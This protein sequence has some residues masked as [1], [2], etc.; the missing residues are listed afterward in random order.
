M[1]QLV[2]AS[3]F[4]Q[5]LTLVAAIDAGALPEADERI[6]VLAD[7]SQTPELTVPLVEQDG[8]AVVAS[9]FDRVVDLAALLDPLRP[10]QF[11]PR[12][13]EHPV[14]ER[15]LRSHWQLGDGP[16]QVVMDFV[17]VDPAFSLAGIFAEA[18]LW[19][20]SDGLMTYSPTRRSLPLRI[21][22]RLC[23]LVHLDLVPGLRPKML[24]EYDVPQ[25]RVPLQ[26]LWAVL[27]EVLQASAGAADPS[28][29][30]RPTALVLGQYLSSLGVVSAEEETALNARL[31]VEAA[32]SGA[33]VCLF[34]PHPAAPPA[35]TLALQAAAEGAGIDLVID[36]SPEI[37]ELTMRRRKPHWVISCFSTGLA[38]ARYLL[39]IEAVA[40]GTRELLVRLNPYENSNRVPL[41]LAHLLFADRPVGGG[42]EAPQETETTDPRRDLQRLVDAVAYCMQPVLL[43]GSVEDVRDYLSAVSDDTELLTTV[44]RRRRL[45]AL[46]LPGGLPAPDPLERLRRSVRRRLGRLSRV[47]GGPSR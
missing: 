28:P 12:L 34:K 19:M 15:L 42:F 3:T 46:D 35:R 1:K 23:G 40:V 21:S 38:G 13:D 37:A 7:G 22:Q 32:R 39:G 45:T 8:F 16:V 33:E 25:R 27:D 44:F 43:A 10:V 24:S 17:Q 41:V 20:H 2:I 9:R 18:D 5:C 36:T 47:S 30:G 29:D 26:S 4:F 14:W 31:V 6:L 11:S